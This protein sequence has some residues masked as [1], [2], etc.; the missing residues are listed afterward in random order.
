M[1]LLSMWRKAV[2]SQRLADQAGAEY[3]AALAAEMA[4]RCVP[5]G[6]A[7][8]VLG[9]GKVKPEK[10]CAALPPDKG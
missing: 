2:T 5:P 1:D 10:D 4:R 8:D 6:Y 3:N 9:D 7:I